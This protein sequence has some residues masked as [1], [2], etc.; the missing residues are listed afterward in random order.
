MIRANCIEMMKEI[1]YNNF[2]ENKKNMAQKEEFE[3]RKIKRILC[4]KSIS[5]IGKCLVAFAILFANAPCRGVLYEPQVPEKLI[6][7]S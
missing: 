7:V 3:M 1:I 4:K 6:K 5:S 2:R